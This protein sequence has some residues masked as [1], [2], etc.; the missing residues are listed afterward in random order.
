M[1]DCEVEELTRQYGGGKMKGYKVFSETWTCRGFKYEVGK[2]YS[3]DDD[4]II[5][6]RGFHFCTNMADCF[7][8]Y[9]FDTRNKVAEIEACGEIVEKGGDSKHATNHIRIVREMS[10]SK[11][12]ELVNMGAGNTGLRNTGNI[13]TGNINTGNRNTG[14]W[15]TGNANTGDWNAGDWNSCD[16][17][18]GCFCTGEQ[19]FILF[20][21]PSPISRTKFYDLNIVKRLMNITLFGGVALSDMTAEEKKAHPEYKITDGYIKLYTYFEA[22]ENLWKTLSVNEKKQ[23]RELPNFDADT[24]KVITG[25]EITQDKE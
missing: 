3:I 15:N 10:W 20:D 13:N 1:S 2:E 12:L 5:C 22:W 14:D 16:Y 19:P 6:V 8:Y 25:I 17:S 23:L 4:P 11:M 24:F 21:K 18:A 7:N 9:L